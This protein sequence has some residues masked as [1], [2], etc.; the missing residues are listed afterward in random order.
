MAAKKKMTR[1]DFIKVAGVATGAA[2]ATK[3]NILSVGAMALAATTTYVKNRSPLVQTPFIP[4]ALGA[5][6]ADGWLLNQLQ[7]LASGA[8]GNAEGIYTELG[9]NAA[10]LGTSQASMAA[11]S[12][13]ERP[14]YYVKGLV[15]LAY[16]LN[17]SGLISKLQKWINW[18]LGSQV[19]S[20]AFGPSWNYFDWWPRMPMLYA[21]KD[22]YEA[23]NDSRVLP[24][25]TNYF[26]F[27]ANNLAAHPLVEWAK[28]RAGDNIE[29]VLWLYNRTG[30]A[31]LLT[32][33]DTLKNQSYN[34]TDIF[35][36][37]KF[38]TF[39]SDI[40]PKHNVNVSQ[41]IKWPAIV[42]QRTNAAA[43]QNAFIAGNNNLLTNH[44]Q[45]TG[46]SSGTEMLAGKSSIQGVELCAIVE[47]MQSN[48]SAQMILGNPVIG[49]QLEKI[50]FN[51]LPGAM[52]KANKIHEYY[53]FPNQYESVR[54]PQGFEE[55]YG[56]GIVLGPNSGFPCC[57]FNLHMGWPYYV[58][59]MW[60]GTSDN[61]VAA[62]VYGPSHVTV[63]VGTGSVDATITEA[64]NYPFEEQIRFT[65]NVP[66]AVAFPLKLRIPA[67][68]AGPTV[69][70]NGAAQSGVVVGAFFT[71]NR[72]WNNGDTVTLNVPMP[73]KTSTQI[74]NSV[75]VERG[76]LVFSLK[77]T[78]NWLQTWTGPLGFNEY[79]ITPGNPWNYGL[80][81]DRNNPGAS[82]SVQTSAMP[83]NPFVTATTPIKLT[84]NARKVPWGTVRA[85]LAAAEVQSS[86]F[87]SSNPT[88]QITLI[89][90]GAENTRITYFPEVTAGAG[91]TTPPPAPFSDG[92][93]N[94]TAQWTTYGG[95]WAI[96]ASN[97]TV[98]AGTGFKAVANGTNFAGLIF[99]ADIMANGG[100][101]GIIFRASNFAVGADSY[102][103]YYAGINTNGN[104]ILGKAN[105]NWTQLAA[106]PMTI[107][108]NTWYHIKVVAVGS[109]IKV[110]VT[111]MNTPKITVTDTSY[112]SGAVGLRT[113]NSTS[114]FDNVSAKSIFIDTFDNG[115]GN[116]SVIDGA[117]SIVTSQY[118]VNAGPGY[119][120]IA[121]GTNFGDV[122]LEGDVNVSGGNAGFIFRGSN[123]SAGADAYFG[124][125]AGIDSGGNVVL[126]LSTGS[127]IQLGSFAMSIP[128]NTWIHLKVVAA[129]SSIQVYVTDMATPKITVTDSTYSSGAIGLRT[130]NATAKF[131][132]INAVSALS[133]VI[134]YQDINYGGAASASKAKGSYAVMP[135][136][137]PNDWMTSMKIPA[138]WTVEVYADGSFAGTK[139]TYTADSPFVGAANDVM[140]SFKI[141]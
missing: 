100:D 38:L 122:T 31:S 76:P 61:G 44:G 123:F 27:Q 134:F 47:R 58:K 137:V 22:F 99:E 49:D 16:T 85:G 106:T 7:L 96:A 83:T 6:R 57:R 37:N 26:H 103:G 129:G 130:Y 62:M 72:T 40:H 32:L 10:W 21:L 15:A 131:D 71:I 66:S 19:A 77:M 135:A 70:V 75:A 128:A 30:E 104:V 14:T 92:F 124:Y 69:L 140:S 81:L 51:A 101:T 52:D 17:D 126:G 48:E 79:E 94:G 88:E 133:G 97:Y 5:V 115:T 18:A 43:D 127:W 56:T 74:N 105:N 102:M 45:V 2:L 117:W 33:A 3:M 24:F 116:W 118:N 93:D 25:L 125:Y 35:T 68:A 121:A 59:N 111:D 53:T 112:V 87:S 46:M 73:L 64:T 65:I 109:L 114:K 138:G 39:G 80:L 78:E 8:T 139:W 4:L 12:D 86:P 23:T 89:P 98:N 9:G 107:T 82:I 55:D 95:T 141:Y 119:K 84:A 113:Y 120:A 108:A 11:D 91:T 67:W 28:A 13:W 63:R 60:A 136:D 1:R 90:F 29:V 54:G 34:Q 36:N 132:A 50:T 42:Y 41:A 110:Y 20:G